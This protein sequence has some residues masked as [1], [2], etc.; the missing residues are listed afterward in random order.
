VLSFFPTSENYR[1]MYDYHFFAT[2]TTISKASITHDFCGN[3]ACVAVNNQYQLVTVQLPFVR[4]SG[5]R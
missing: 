5:P 1:S 4:Q 2:G 3:T